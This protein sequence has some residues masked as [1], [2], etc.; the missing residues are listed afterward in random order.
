MPV[1]VAAGLLAVVG[2]FDIVGTV[3]S[4]YLTDRV[5][6]RIL[7][8][9]YYAFRGVG[10]A[11]LP[12]L[13]SDAVHP[14]MV[15]FVVVY[16]LDWVAT[17]PP[18]VALCRRIFGADG[19]VVFGWVFASHQLGAAAAASLG[20]IVRDVTGAYTYAWLGGAALCAIAAVLSWVVRHPPAAPPAAAAIAATR[21][22]S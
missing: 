17:V 7:L 16:G 9:A 12:V 15:L 11:L 20:G 3:A 14:S 5:D 18:T 2:I 8:V 4:G 21:E 22:M 1:T 19:T 6:P 13:L 10:L